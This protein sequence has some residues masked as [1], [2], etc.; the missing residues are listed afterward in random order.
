[1]GLAASQARLLSIT[2]RMSD[3]ELRAQLI[4]NQKMRLS[5]KS[6]QVSENYINAL[7]KT[8]L[9]FAN[10]D[11]NDN[12][13]NVPLTFNN[14]T[15]FNQY[16]NQYGLTNTAGNILISE[17][18]AKY[19]QAA[20]GAD[21]PQAEFLRQHGIEY[22]TSYW[23]TLS[24]QLGNSD[25]TYTAEQLKTMYEGVQDVDNPANN[26]SSYAETIKTQEYT[27]FSGYL[28]DFLTAKAKYDNALERAT[29]E[30]INSIG[31]KEYN[32][33]GTNM[34]LNGIIEAD[35][36]NLFQNN[37][38]TLKT[39]LTTV[40]NDNCNTGSD[41]TGFINNHFNA[42]NED[43]I[44]LTYSGGKFTSQGTYA[45]L[46]LGANANLYSNNA[47]S[48][49]LTY[50][51]GGNVYMNI[52]IVTVDSSGNNVVGWVKIGTVSGGSFTQDTGD[53]NIYKKDG[54]NM[55]I[56]TDTT[57]DGATQNMTVSSKS[58]NNSQFTYSMPVE[59]DDGSGGIINSTQS[60]TINFG[61]TLNAAN[62]ASGTGSGTVAGL[63]TT[64]SGD[65]NG[66]SEEINTALTTLLQ[67]TYDFL[68]DNMKDID[69]S[70]SD[71]D[72]QAALTECINIGQNLANTILGTN[73][74]GSNI[75][76]VNKDNINDLYNYIASV[77]DGEAA[78]TDPCLGNVPKKEFQ[79]VVNAYILDTMMDIF[80][81]PV[82]GYLYTDGN[83]KVDTTKSNTDASAEAKWY[84][85]LFEKINS[86]GYQVLANGLASSTEW[87]QFALENG[88]VVMQQ[89]TSDD[90]W[91]G[92][93]YTSCSDISEQTDSNAA[94]IAEAEYNQA[95]RQIEA[96][97]EMYDLEL[98][99]IDTEHSSLEAEYESVKK[100]MSGNIERNFQ[101]YS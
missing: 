26:V 75:V 28:D 84:I 30:A 64:T 25:I 93:T 58:Y 4:N 90:S 95:M 29:Q 1:M 11:A 85:N 82:Y 3:N 63:T 67:D 23:D 66:M 35:P 92:I 8:N 17:T 56:A 76:T 79:S 65:K 51:N 19:Y 16:N 34:T 15:A 22:T 59:C 39:L 57:E 53:L 97:D 36:V 83:G 49:S 40:L 71:A 31:D 60:T 89:V 12:A 41:V 32:I 54:S 21:D 94:T 2:S 61:T 38:N 69:P 81:E 27:D 96:K 44:N 88:I 37:A 80:G 72:V 9:M 78:S 43:Y 47:S 24:E 99:N 68:R 62:L 20:M 73:A 33:G 5:A 13:Q 45:D 10:Y 101:M 77:V 74:D 100:A 14:L 52:G 48:N 87:L 46:G 86:S 42:G 6:S 7:N 98:K 50:T 70:S 55:V 18:E 91:E